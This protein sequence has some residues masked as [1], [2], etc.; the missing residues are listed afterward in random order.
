[1]TEGGAAVSLVDGAATTKPRG[2]DAA[3]FSCSTTPTYPCAAN[4][5]V[6]E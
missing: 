4:S 3:E 2:T 1:M 6:R 5:A